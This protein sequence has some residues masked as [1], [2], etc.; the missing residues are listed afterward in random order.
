MSQFLHSAEVRHFSHERV[1][2]L[3]HNR[4]IFPVHTSFGMG[5]SLRS[6]PITALLRDPVCPPFC[7]PR[8][9]G[10][11]IMV[12]V[13]P[14][15]PPRDH[16]IHHRQQVPRG[17]KGSHPLHVPNIGTRLTASCPLTHE[18]KKIQ[19]TSPEPYRSHG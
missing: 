10:S 15:L 19:L 5:P 8:P 1:L 12:T 13:H 4:A 14:E 17:I 9:R 6:K 3:L 16:A 11:R 7:T 2:A 18:R